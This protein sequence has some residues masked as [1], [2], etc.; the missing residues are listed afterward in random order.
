VEFSVRAKVKRLALFHHDPYH[1]D[2]FV[3]GMVHHAQ[4]ILAGQKSTIECFG[5]KE[6]MEVV[7]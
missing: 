7:L 4:Q 6:G 3:D 5:A 2:A 1:D